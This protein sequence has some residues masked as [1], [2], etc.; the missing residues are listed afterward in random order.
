MDL[1]HYRDRSIKYY[2]HPQHYLRTKQHTHHDALPYDASMIAQDIATWLSQL[3]PSAQFTH[4]PSL[5]AKPNEADC[6]EPLSPPESRDTDTETQP[7]RKR[8]SL[9]MPEDSHRTPKRPRLTGEIGDH[10]RDLDRDVDE[11][12]RASSSQHTRRKRTPHRRLRAASPAHSLPSRSES[13]STSISHVSG[14]S[15]PSKQIAAL[16][17]NADGIET[18]VMAL[19]DAS[20][21]LSLR[22][23]LTEIDKCS[24]CLRI[25]SEDL[26][27]EIT[28]RKQQEEFGEFSAV[29]DFAYVDTQARD[30]LGPTPSLEEVADLVEDAG[31][32]QATMQNE[33]GWNMM[34]HYPVLRKAVYGRQKYNQ[35]VGVAP[36]T[37]ARI[38]KE[39]LPIKSQPKMVDF[40]LYLNPDN[41][42]SPASPVNAIRQLRQVLPCNVMNHTDYLSFRNCPIAVSI[43]TKKRGTGREDAE[44]QVGT[45]HAAQ[46]NFL[47]D[48]VAE[49]GGS[50]DGLDFLPAVVIQGHEW[51]FVATTREGR[52]TVLWLEKHFGSTT[53]SLGVYKIVWALQRLARWS[54]DV[55]WPWYKSNV[56]GGQQSI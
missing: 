54:E 18:R 41:D 42:L 55:F 1:S 9:M 16:E 24:N 2:L 29:E 36:C 26:R 21:T 51:N 20:M 46:W 34:V 13:E 49:T 50:L 38:I 31:Q 10:G 25:L 40:C 56:L 45:W 44:L 11:T 48:R 12:P 52:K 7:R 30:Q 27:A 3:D 4:I 19:T 5:D 32:C 8:N 37:T 47:Q 22:R 39:Y 33:A 17:L 15:S 14:R 35:L 28:K 6:H 53:S 23:L 43:E